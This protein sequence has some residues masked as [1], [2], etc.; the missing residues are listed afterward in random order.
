MAEC[1]DESVQFDYRGILQTTREATVGAQKR[2]VGT[3]NATKSINGLCSSRTCKQLHVTPSRKEITSRHMLGWGGRQNGQISSDG[4][5]LLQS[6]HEHEDD[7]NTLFAIEDD[8]EVT[9]SS[10]LEASHPSRNNTDHSVR[11]QDQVQVI[12]PPLRSTPESREAGVSSR[13][14]ARD[15]AH[16]VPFN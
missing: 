7:E 9:E 16:V 5:P 12:A 14:R 15:I 4:Q 3:G 6:S 8:D 1:R 13:V 10:A 2:C 11:F